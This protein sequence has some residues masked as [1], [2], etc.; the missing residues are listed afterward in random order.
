MP[1]YRIPREHVFPDPRLADPSGLLGVG[2][3]LHPARVLL[4]YRMGIFPWF[5]EGDPILWHCPDPRV[6]LYPEEMHVPRSLGKRIRQERYR[7][8]M[9]QAFDQVIRA[10][11]ETYRPGQGGTWITRGM[12]RTYRALHQAD[13]AHSI[14]AWEGEQLV[15]GLYGVSIGDVFAGESMFARAPD[16][17]KV[18]FVHFVRQFQRWGGRLIDCQVQTEHLKR[19]GARPISRDAYL[20]ALVDGRD[21]ML[22]SGPWTFDDD[23]ATDGR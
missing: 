9:N 6:V 13:L 23:F 17:S 19:F 11:S 22:H 18:A 3:D 1:V 5:N 15:G 2:G 16:A 14:E 20:Q 12:E 8:T 21:R 7:I 4:A 10:C